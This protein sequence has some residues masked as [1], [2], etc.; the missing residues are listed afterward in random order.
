[1]LLRRLR[2]L[3]SF[4]FKISDIGSSQASRSS[5]VS[6][7]LILVSA[8]RLIS[9]ANFLVSAAKALAELTGV[10][11]VEVGAKLVAVSTSAP[12]LV[13]VAA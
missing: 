2:R 6:F 3:G 7:A 12:E 5:A 13:T 10:S 11:R 1:R 4:V 9:S 8:A